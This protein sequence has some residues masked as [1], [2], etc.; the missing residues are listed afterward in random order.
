MPGGEATDHLYDCLVLGAGIAGVTAARD[1]RRRGHDVLL[2]EG[3]DRI[4]GRMYSKGGVVP[5]PTDPTGTV[6]IEAGAEYIHV[7]NKERYEEFWREIERHGFTVSKFPKTTIFDFPP[8]KSGEE[9]SEPD[10]GARNRVFFPGWERPLRTDEVLVQ[11]AEIRH[12]SGMLAFMEVRDLFDPSKDEDVSAGEFVRW[13]EENHHYR[14][15]GVVMSEYT[16]SAHT[17]GLLDAPPPGHPPDEPNPNDTISVAGILKDEIQD[18]LLEPAEFRLELPG[19]GSARVCGYD[20]LPR[21]I[22]EELTTAGGAIVKS[23]DGTTDKKVTRVERTA[24]GHVAIT[25]E[26]GSRY[27][28]RS[29]VSTFAAGMLDPVEGEGEAIFGELLTDFKRRALELVDMGPI[30]KFSLV[31]RERL[32]APA[33][34]D[35]SVLSNPTGHARTFFSAFPD[36]AEAGPHVLTALMMSTDHLWIRDKPDGVAIQLLLDELQKIF[37]PD[38]ERWTPEGVLLGERDDTGRFVP[39]YHRQDWEKDPFARGGN[40]YLR[41]VPPDEA[42]VKVTRA[43]ERL[44]DPRETLPLFWAGEATAPA[45]DRRYQPLSVH[46]A[47]ISGVRVA[48]DVDHW[49]SDS[50]GDAGEFDRYYRKRYLDRGLLR[51]IGDFFRDLFG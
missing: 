47:Y 38:G 40:S 13:L 48:E 15:R 34:T 20:A 2:I 9:P 35:M 27:L 44:K 8:S 37:D 26:D 1:L 28:G 31:F 51:R 42:R 21:R 49:L 23:P 22:A 46:G 32:W 36:E 29:A 4:G 7:V 39:R 45:Y 16:L 18:Q 30:T 6:P 24:D 19:D 43:R 14:D 10:K 41:Y 11:D 33:A 25:T 17:P 3:S 5:D 50:G 12:A